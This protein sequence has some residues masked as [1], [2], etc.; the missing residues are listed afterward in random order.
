MAFGSQSTLCKT[1]G[2]SVDSVMH[3]VPNDDHFR[4]CSTAATRRLYLE[5]DCTVVP[6]KV[7]VH[8]E[9]NLRQKILIGK[10]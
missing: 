4:S 2:F 8:Y 7:F 3:E 1:L 10:E 6:I 5:I 9:L